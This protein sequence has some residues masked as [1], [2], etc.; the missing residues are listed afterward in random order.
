VTVPATCEVWIDGARFA[1]APGTGAPAA[2]DDLGL[3]WGRD[4]RLDQ[5]RAAQLSVKVLDRGTGPPWDTLVGL[6][7]TVPVWCQV[8]PA[9]V[10]PFTGRVTDVTAEWDADLAGTVIELAAADRLADLG[11]R[12]V[13][14]E[15]WAA[16][17]W[18]GRAHRITGQGGADW[19][20]IP[21]PPG[22]LTVS[23]MDVDRQAM[24][25]LLAELGTTGGTIVFPAMFPDG[26]DLLVAQNP[27]DR[28]SLVVLG[29]GTDGLWRPVPA[30]G[31]GAYELSACDVLQDPVA[32]S[33]TSGDLVTR[34]TVRWRDQTGSPAPTERSVAY[35]NAA[36]ETRWGA[37]GL[38][39][40]TILTT[41]AAATDLA[42]ATLVRNQASD[43]Y[44]AT[45]LVWDLDRVTGDQA[46]ADELA[47][48]LLDSSERTGTAVSLTDLPAWTP[49]SADAGGYVE[50]GGYRFR[51]GRWV[52]TLVTTS[53]VGAGSS[54][55]YADT[56]R[57][58]PA[59]NQY[60]PDVSYLDLLGV[61]APNVV[62][63]AAAATAAA[64]DGPAVT[65]A[66]TTPEGLPYP[67]PTDPYCNTAAALQ[68]LAQA[69]DPRLVN[70]PI[71][72]I[73]KATYPTDANGD[74]IVD[75]STTFTSIDGAV[76]SDNGGGYPNLLQVVQSTGSVQNKLYI[77]VLTTTPPD[78]NVWANAS[79]TFALTV[80]GTPK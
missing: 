36:D 23:R 31:A 68:S 77:R 41:E 69:I 20:T 33:R 9:R 26:R 32:W 38:S 71:Q 18:W 1:D 49:A 59:Y 75:L 19:A 48:R 6:G 13:G 65:P 51:H 5:P 52:L 74:A 43:A 37:R 12:F 15:P 46:A 28:A 56:P 14:A 16:E 47:A 40:G 25:G 63:T 7:S 35:V 67:E 11:N 8:G 70:L 39:L 21:F 34:V 79:G 44:R 29:V 72:F 22:D 66:G 73:P 76:V 30:A 42:G 58:A 50:G 4:N 55:S 78:G 27:N 61:G 10:S 54:I 57:P 60:A 17:P 2:L 53:A 45:G 24:A 62:V 3:V 80:W 64:A